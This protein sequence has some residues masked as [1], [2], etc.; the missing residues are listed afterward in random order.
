VTVILCLLVAS[1]ML[2]NLVKATTVLARQT[3]HHSQRLQLQ[4]LTDDAM[5]HALNQFHQQDS[6]TKETWEISP[7]QWSLKQ[8]GRVKID[9]SK[10]ES[11][12]T[13]IITVQGSI[14]QDKHTLQKL[15]KTIEVK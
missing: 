7:D 6:Y 2:I 14:L 9:V 13:T 12:K 3:T 5:S 1:A 4:I 15:T 10:N 11:N 8:N